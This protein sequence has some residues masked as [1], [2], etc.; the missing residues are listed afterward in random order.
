MRILGVDPGLNATGFGCVDVKNSF[1]ACLVDAGTIEPSAKENLATRLY[2]VH[3][4]LNQIITQH[5]PDLMVLEKLYSHHKHPA[6]VAVLGHVRGVICLLGA[7]RKL[8]IV[9]YP[10]K[11]IRKAITGNGN[12]TK[13]QTQRTV[14]HLLK[15]KSSSR[16]KWDITDALA[17]ALG[18]MWMDRS[19]R[20]TEKN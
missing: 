8:E 19:R 5:Q 14:L 9:E 1:D 11:R 15:I 20:L 3:S 4:H 7:E 2:K 17:L 6:T 12:A 10:V 13:E 18:H 16:I